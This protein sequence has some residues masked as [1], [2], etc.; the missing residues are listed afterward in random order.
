MAR[1]N[2]TSIYPVSTN[3]D[4]GIVIGSD[5]DNNGK[6]VN[7]SLDGLK[8]FFGTGKEGKSAY[9][10]WLSDGN[11]G[12]VDDYL[13]SLKGEKGDSGTAILMYNDIFDI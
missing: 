11:V 9:E 1:I 4:G 10:V 2:K 12:T 8:E 3:Y 7:Y 5:T 13:A 6:T